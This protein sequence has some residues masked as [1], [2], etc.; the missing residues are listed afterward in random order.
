MAFPRDGSFDV[1]GV[2][3]RHAGERVEGEVV[4]ASDGAAVGRQIA[5]VLALDHDA[6]E[7]ARV[8]EREPALHEASRARPGFRPVVSYSP[9]VMGGWSVLSQRIRM[10]QAAAVQVRIAEAAGDVVEVDGDVIAS[11]P[12]PQS[13]LARP[14]FAGVPEEKWTRLQAVARAALDGELEVSTLTALPYADARDR[15]MRVRG[16]GSWTADAI[17]MRGCGPADTLPLS[18]PSLHTAVCDAYRLR[19]LPDDSTVESIA[20]AWRPFRMWVSVL[21][22]SQALRGSGD[23]RPTRPLR[24]GMPR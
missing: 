7:F 5:R 8:L 21:L 17:L 4:G 6:T 18:E 2:T 24:R 19:E 9:Y 1:V 10:A 12:R 13:L 11:F 16:V 14:S 20:E 22:I 23:R 3:V 15:L